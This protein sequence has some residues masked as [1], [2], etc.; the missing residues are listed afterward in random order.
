MGKRRSKGEGTIR[1]RKDGVWEGRFYVN[2]VQ[3]SIYSG[4]QNDI[5]KKMTE[6]LAELDKDEF[7]I[8]NN[9]TLE[10][11][12]TVWQE[13]YL[14]DVKDSTADRYKSC[15]RV[16]IIPSLG[17][18]PISNLKQPVIQKFLNECKLKKK[19]SKKSVQNI[20]LVI[21]KAM[22]EAVECELIKKNP[23]AKTKVPAY[24]EPK[25][26][27][28]PITGD[29]ITEFL[30]TIKGNE[31]EN[32][33][34][35]AL[36]TGARESE[37]IGL[38][39]DCVDFSTQKIHL[40]RQLKRSRGK[41]SKYVFS[42]LKN[43]QART[44]TAPKEVIDVLKKVKLNQNEQRLKIG[45][46]WH[47]P[48]NLV[49]TNEVGTHIETVSLYRSFKKVAAGMGIPEL[50]FHDLRHSYATL[51]L[52]RGVDSKTVSMNLGHATV[53]FTLDKYG[54][55]SEAMMNDSA[56]KLQQFIESI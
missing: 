34:F 10:Q 24:S 48:D 47:N 26:E 38:S 13:T 16:H 6:S 43:N 51:A 21:N 19:L 46:A 9:M 15:I 31:Y 45:N 27:M 11:W 40:Y 35:V 55:V 18:I 5:R 7:L 23:C 30:E 42:S 50:R 14:S 56:T 54:H 3:R 44:F 17:K 12:L 53:A 49:F 33:F 1:K 39:W 52:E 8:E 4:S 22:T 36:F 20:R 25:K 29:E 41:N 32:L 28:R 2:G 37:L